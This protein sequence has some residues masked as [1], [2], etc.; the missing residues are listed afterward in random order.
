MELLNFQWKFLFMWCRISKRNRDGCGCC[1]LTPLRM[2]CFLYGEFPSL[3]RQLFK[4]FHNEYIFRL[5]L[6]I[7]GG[8]VN[9]S[10]NRPKL[11]SWGS[12]RSKIPSKPA[13]LWRRRTKRD[14]VIWLQFTNW[15]HLRFFLIIILLSYS[16]F[17]SI[18]VAL[19]RHQSLAVATAMC[20][21]AKDARVYAYAYVE[22]DNGW[23]SGINVVRLRLA[24][25]FL[26]SSL[27]SSS[28]LLPLLMFLF[29]NSVRIQKVQST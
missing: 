22:K 29:V 15:D 5:E 13:S 14:W 21:C 16:P 17:R 26:W 27:S 4:T 7:F 11:P 10:S 23:D 18:V 24:K 20:I 2:D 1:A 3:S 8:Q 19:I 28:S 12:L 9:V 25:P 6:E